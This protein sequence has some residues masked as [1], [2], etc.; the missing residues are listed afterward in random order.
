LNI[1]PKNIPFKNLLIRFFCFS[2]LTL[3]N[4]NIHDIKVVDIACGC[5]G[6]LINASRILKQKTEKSYKQIFKRNIFGVDIQAYSVKRT[7]ILLIILIT[8]QNKF[9]VFYY[10]V[11]L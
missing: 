11:I 1:H 4:K 7:E 2:F 9:L 10:P 3:G 5:G 6:F 8:P